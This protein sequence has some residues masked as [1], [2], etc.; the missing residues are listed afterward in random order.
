MAPGGRII[1][2]STSLCAASTLTPN[3]T[4]YIT[5]KGAI[6]QLTRGLSKELSKKGIMVNAIAPGPTAT[7]LF[8][9][10]KSEQLLKMIAGF[11]P[12]NRIG[13]PEEIAEVAA[14]LSGE[15]SSWVTGQVIRTNGGFV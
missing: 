6:E 11:N 10:G 14:F 8:L 5:S 1:L 13:K 2:F 4:L 3:Y 12:Q 7:D 15:G 9:E